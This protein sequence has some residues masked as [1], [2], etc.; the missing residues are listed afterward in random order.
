M[1][2]N[3]VREIKLIE[4]LFKERKP[5]LIILYGRRRVGKTELLNE[6]AKKHK[7][8]YLVARQESERDQL[9]KLSQDI[10]NFYND[11]VLR[12]N[13][14]RNYDSLF[15]YL[16]QK[17][18]PIIFDE[19]PY[20]VESNKA[21]PSILQE[22][23]DKQFSKKHSFIVLCGSS[24]TMMESLLG[25]KSP[26]YGRR[27]EQI[28]LEPLPFKDAC[29]FF[30][31]LRAEQKVINYAVLGGTPAYLL[32]FDHSKPLLTNIKDKIL[33]RN[34]FLYQDVL[35]VIQ[36]ELNE[37]SIYY[38]IIKSI[39][40]GNTKLG[41]IINDTGL[42]KS[43]ISKYLSVLQDLRLIE[44][45]VPITEKNPEKSRNG[46]YV[47]KD[48]YFRFWFEF[49][50]ENSRYIEQ[51]KQ[52]QLI[53]IIKQGLNTF[54]GRA[55]EQIAMDWAKEK[56]RNYLIG[57]WWSRT[58]EIDIVG[59]DG[60]KM[61]FG[62]VKWKDLN[63]KQA[64]QILAGLKEKAEELHKG[65]QHLII[66]AKTIKGKQALTKDGYYAFDLNDILN[67]K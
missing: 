64:R 37:P 6:F 33:Q 55:Y 60:P 8:L 57:R 56:F 29:Q 26:L 41:N 1:F 25:Y 21:L 40:K 47:L 67:A 31:G 34:K 22:Y 13:P 44:R 15:T 65:K 32:E 27:T 61:L 30:D 46:I 20:L 19:F 49:I 59:I 28:L 23:W 43:K 63:E 4:T 54:I 51:N 2:I 14:F 24:I 45:Q 12:L 58:D 52:D 53:R 10:A 16:T 11:K 48:N 42:E 5:K 62:E 36:Q 35:F 3:R 9:L 17:E 18:T 39:A 66:I 7:A 50:F 38:S